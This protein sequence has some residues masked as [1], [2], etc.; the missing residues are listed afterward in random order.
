[1]C[2]MHLFFILLPTAHTLAFR[3]GSCSIASI[4]THAPQLLSSTCSWRHH[5]SSRIISPP[6]LRFRV[7]P[8]ASSTLLH[9]TT[10]ERY[11]GETY[12]SNRRREHGMDSGCTRRTSLLASSDQ[13]ADDGE[14]HNNG[15]AT[16]NGANA[17]DTDTETTLNSNDESKF[18]KEKESNLFGMES[19]WASFGRNIL[20]SWTSSPP[21][22]S[23]PEEINTADEGI[24]TKDDESDKT[25]E[26]ETGLA[27]DPTTTIVL[28]SVFSPNGTADNVEKGGVIDVDILVDSRVDEPERNE[29]T[30]IQLKSEPEDNE[31]TSIKLQS[32]DVVPMS[33][34]TISK[35]VLRGLMAVSLKGGKKLVKVSKKIRDSRN[36]DN[37]SS[38]NAT[39]IPTVNGDPSTSEKIKE[40][41]SNLEG[42]V[43]STDPNKTLSDDLGNRRQRR[44]R[45]RQLSNENTPVMS[46][47]L[48]SLEAKDITT[49]TRTKKRQWARRRKRAIVLLKTTKNAAILF[50][51]TFLAGNVMN[52]FVDLD[53]DGS[54]EVHFGKSLSSSS[55]SPPTTPVPE[56]TELSTKQIKKSLFRTI[57][58]PTQNYNVDGARA[59]ALG[60]V[61]NAVQRVGPAT[62]RVETETHLVANGA[63]TKVRN[64][65]G[66]PKNEKQEKKKEQLNDNNGNGEF[67]NE[68][69][70]R[71]DIFDGVPEAPPQSDDNVG[72]NIDFGQGSGIIVNS[73]GYIL[74]NAHVVASATKIY[75]LLNDGRRFRVEIQGSDD[76]VDIA[77]LK[78]I[79]DETTDKSN[80]RKQMSMANLPVAQL[81]NSD[82][83]EVG[84]FVTAIGS[85][86]GLDNTC[87]LGIVSGL[88]RCPKVVGIPDKLGALDYIQ[89]DAAI[90]Q[91]NSGGPLVD[92]ETGNIVGINTCIRAN[93]EGTSFAIPINKVMGIV[94][95]LAEGKHITHGYLGVHMSTMNPTLARYYNK[96]Q[97]QQSSRK[98]PER[99]GVM[100][101][102]VFRKS[103]AKEG[104]LKK[105]DF[106]TQIGGQRVETAD[107]AHVI[108]DRATIGEEL[109]IKVMRE[110]TEITVQVK[111][112]DLSPRL[113]QLREERL[114]RKK[115]KAKESR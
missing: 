114:K 45:L 79:P 84:Q 69:E 31:A 58:T 56:N 43:K 68:G 65:P 51:I 52:Q 21:E 10:R 74:T 71:G 93:M 1:M 97:L 17:T 30:S 55:P 90:N 73:D 75:V 95:D 82:Q 80:D 6:S 34:R 57:A 9:L 92:V 72:Q 8:D 7:P 18:E 22:S 101:E 105:F 40:G 108:I 60:L 32:E 91:G 94:D 49:T 78:I 16:D 41:A 53:E 77:V 64:G 3:S 88:K 112:E 26:N 104:G 44:S 46:P 110:D 24:N 66:K 70:D 102:K 23:M 29:T 87:T 83:M 5:A 81:G 25:N 111:P 103:P 19:G 96:L 62:V 39:S 33:K 109:S 89:T 85:P 37:A 11:G 14:I 115:Q 13:D 36:D 50:V 100:I 35:N 15:N 59:E 86:G 107:D 4:R 38:A 2:I 67:S 54:F 27:I 12:P 20:P 76:I 47:F 42:A 99:E 28:T 48:N 113:K 98:I 106:V 61:K 63:D